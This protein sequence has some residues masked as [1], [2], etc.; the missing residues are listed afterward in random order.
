MLA[1]GRAR[2]SSSVAVKSL[3]KVFDLAD[4]KG[5]EGGP[6][7]QDRVVKALKHETDAAKA[8]DEFWLLARELQRL[9]ADRSLNKDEVE[10]IRFLLK[11]CTCASVGRTPVGTIANISHI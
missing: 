7:L 6:S 8:S 9:L 3:Q 1:R 5:S 11:I 4:E 10:Y 2:P